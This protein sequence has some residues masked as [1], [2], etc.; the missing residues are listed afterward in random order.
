MPRVGWLRFL[1]KLYGFNLAI[2]RAFAASFDGIKAQIGDV[3]LKLTEEFVS[4][5]TGLPWVGERW[6]KG[7][8]VKN[9]DWKE[10]LTPANWQMKYKSSFPSRLLK[11]K[12]HSLLELIIRYITC[13]GRLSQTH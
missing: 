12:W 4:R 8:H 1:Q 11:N 2:S 13:E 9:D 7:K 3:E 10:F 6:Y 5:A